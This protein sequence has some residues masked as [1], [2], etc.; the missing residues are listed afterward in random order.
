MGWISEMRRRLIMEHGRNMVLSRY[1]GNNPSVTVRAYG[2]PPQTATLGDYGLS[3]DPFIVQITNDETGAAGWKPAQRDTLMDGDRPYTLT[4]A[5]PV[6]DK[7]VLC[8][9]TLIAAGGE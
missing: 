9:W 3:I 7:G 4:D 6:Y 1:G 2:P 8:G 5:T